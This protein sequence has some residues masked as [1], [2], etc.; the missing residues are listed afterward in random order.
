[1]LC[2]RFLWFGAG[3]A[4]LYYFPI[5]LQIYFFE[6]LLANNRFLMSRSISAALA[7]YSVHFGLPTFFRRLPDPSYVCSFTG[8][9]L[10]AFGE[11]MAIA[12]C[13]CAFDAQAHCFVCF[14]L[15]QSRNI[16]KPMLLAITLS[17]SGTDAGRPSY[18]CSRLLLC[19][20]LK[21]LFRSVLLPIILFTPG[22][23][24]RK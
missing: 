16:F 4:T 2:I 17:T 20:L 21:P 13:P 24:A 9:V 10:R 8:A 19:R 3:E 22:A 7:Q 12:H 5:N 18:R 15:R 11:F 23:Q 1:M 14:L 6:A